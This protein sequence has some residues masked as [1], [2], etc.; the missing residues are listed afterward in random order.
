VP[1]VQLM[2]L[3]VYPDSITTL[4]ERTSVGEILKFRGKTMNKI[5]SLRDGLIEMER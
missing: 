3:F 2:L 5:L 4:L 1:F